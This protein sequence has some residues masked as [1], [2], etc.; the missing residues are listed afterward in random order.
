MA[1]QIS[2]DVLKS[3]HGEHKTCVPHRRAFH[4]SALEK[5][6]PTK[7]ACVIVVNINNTCRFHSA[8]TSH[9][10]HMTFTQFASHQS[11]L[12]N[13]REQY[14]AVVVAATSAAARKARHRQK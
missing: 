2:E 4:Q 8:A 1:V 5:P 6:L 3:P 13:I 9:D 11:T 12:A 7:Q 10:E 14:G